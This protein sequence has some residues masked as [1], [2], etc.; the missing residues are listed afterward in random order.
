M[1]KYLTVIAVTLIL[2]SCANPLNRITAQ[3]YYYGGLQ[4]QNN[5]KWGDA[6]ISFSRAYTNTQWGNLSDREAA[7]YAYEYGRTS[8]AVCD[9]DNAKKGLEKAL[10]LDTKTNTPLHFD[11]IEFA[12]M[13]QAMGDFTESEKF[14]SKTLENLDK[15]N[16]LTKFPTYY[17]DTLNRYSDVLNHLGK[18][19]QS[20]AFKKRAEMI[21][22]NNP[23]GEPYNAIPYGEFCHQKPKVSK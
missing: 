17:A 2:S 14:F 19:S 20:E 3:Q 12:Q 5:G 11:L 18:K 16:V 1:Y 21:K 7:L 13:Y 22:K 4:S 15:H 23:D 6:T 8:G 9:W 10:Q